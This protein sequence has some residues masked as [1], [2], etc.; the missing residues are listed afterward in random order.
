MKKVLSFLLA[1]C[2]CLS[3]V[4][5]GVLQLTAKA[6]S[7]TL[8]SLQSKYP[9]GKYW[10]HV[11]SSSNNENGYTN[12]P[13]P[14]HSSTN[15]CNAFTYGGIE[16]GWQCYGFALKLGYDI[17]GTNP[18]NWERIKNLDSIKPGDIINYDGNNPGHTVFVTAVNGNTVSFAECNYGGRCIIRWDRS[19]KKSEF[20]NL[21]NVYVA[22]YAWDGGIISCSCSTSYSGNYICT[23]SSVNLTIR[24]GHGTSYS[25]VG[26][27]PSGA[28]VY[29]SKANGTWA[30]VT[31][32]GISGYASMEYLKIPHTHSYTTYYEAAHP[33][34][35][36][37]KCSCEDWAYT[38]ATKLLNTCK[39]CWDIG[40]VSFDKSTITLVKPTSQT[41]KL[42]IQLS[43]NWPDGAGYTF[44]YDSNIISLSQN[45]KE[46]TI[47]AKNTGSTKFTMNIVNKNNNNAVMKSAVC[48]I[49]VKNATY[50]ISY[51]ANGGTGAPSSETKKYDYPIQISTKTPTWTGHTFLGWSKSQTATSATYKSGALY[52]ENAGC[53]LYAVW[54]VNQYKVVYNPNGGDGKSLET[55][56]TYDVSG[57]LKANVFAKKGYT[58][59]GWAKS[60]NATKPTYSVG[61]TVKN[62]SSVNGDIIQLYAVWKPSFYGDLDKSGRV[63][64]DDYTAMK[65]IV[66]EKTKPNAWM[67]LTADLNGDGSITAAD[68][69]LLDKFGTGKIT[70]FPVETMEKKLVIKPYPDKRAYCVNDEIS[71][72][73]IKV[74]L[75]YP[76]TDVYY[77]VTDYYSIKSLPSTSTVGTKSVTVGFR[78]YTA[79]YNINILKPSISLSNSAISLHAG[80]TKSIKATTTP[81]SQSVDWSSSNADVVTVSS[82][83]KI[84]AKSK[85]TARITA[86]FKYNGSTI[87]N[88]CDV[89]V[90]HTQKSPNH[91]YSVATCKAPKTCK[92]CGLTSGSKLSHKYDAGKVTKKATCEKTG[93]KT[94]TCTACKSTK[95]ETIS[96][97]NHTYKDYVCKTCGKWNEKSL[98]KTQK[99]NNK[100]YYVVED[101]AA[102]QTG[103]YGK[104]K[105]VKRL[106]KGTTIIVTQRVYNSWN[107]KWFKCDAGY[108]YAN[109]VKKHESCS[110]SKEKVTKKATCKATGKKEKK[111]TVCGKK[112]ITIIANTKHK[113]EKNVCKVCGKWDKNSL[114]ATKKVSNK[115]YYVVVDDAAIQ[116]GPYGKCKVVKRLAKGTKITVTQIV[117]NSWNNKWFKCSKGYIYSKNLKK[118]K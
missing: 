57:T 72:K 103:P 112:K 91:N 41:A 66:L 44:D 118:Q 114:N 111:C 27:I 67:K 17:Y 46:L 74:S 73:G 28:T 40:K 50:T 96:K 7:V 84:T 1:L 52:T 4:P 14:S 29:V 36:Y 49:T 43:Q 10:N 100:K 35:V 94:Y 87:S 58:L 23:T 19:L 38:G 31:Y 20:N 55:V 26:S 79:S 33:H 56:H 59:I 101:D 51:N 47:T 98:K 75:Y 22:P 39:S 69:T 9:H 8:A 11:G 48:T 95:T 42:T 68:L 64:Y 82:A 76:K 61:A 5:V 62:L 104:C 108:I 37:N 25:A 90:I 102:I 78:D 6:S 2:M 117:Y 89:T 92:V 80:E 109:N 32:N 71:L 97:L 65:N 110:W 107:N 106:A 86:T 45:V 77:D 30:H 18:R 99:V 113:Y 12:T 21:Y 116:T 24:S 85:G 70:D 115:K 105:V 34:K 83:G 88:T 3:V 60:S 16:L 54:K 13:C 81:S 15:T 63:D 93:V 53:T